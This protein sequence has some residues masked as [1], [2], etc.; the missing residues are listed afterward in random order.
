MITELIPI[1]ETLEDRLM[2]EIQ[3]IRTSLDK[4]RRKQFADIGTLRKE[5]IQVKQDHEDWK[6]SICTQ[7]V[8]VKLDDKI[9]YRDVIFLLQQFMID[10]MK[11]LCPKD[12]KKIT[13]EQA[14]DFLDKW[15]LSHF[16]INEDENG[17]RTK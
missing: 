11:D 6:N 16:E 2:R 12:Y 17:P 14:N 10:T 4:C 9:Y 1:E 8:P 15:C 13:L 5:V 3:E 7:E